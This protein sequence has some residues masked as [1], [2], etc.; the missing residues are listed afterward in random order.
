M[1]LL[2]NLSINRRLWLILLLAVGLSLA[3]Y[4]VMLQLIDSGLRAGKAEKIQHSLETSLGILQYFHG[5][6][7]AGSLTR[8]QAQTQA[9]TAVRGLRYAGDNYYWINDLGPVM[10]MHPT[11]TKLE[12]QDLSTIK[13]PDGKALFNEMVK[14]ANSRG[15]G[16]VDYRWPKPGS[17][18]P[19]PKISYVQLFQPWG[20]IIGTGVYID[21]IESE[22]RQLVIKTGSIALLICG[23][24]AVLVLLISRSVTQPMEQVV[25]ALDNIASG[26]GD[27]TQHLDAQGHD[28]LTQLAN[29]FNQFEDKLRQL[30]S[31]L[32]E[33]A[34]TL[35]QSSDELDQIS[36]RG[37]QQ[38]Q[39]QAQQMDL[40][41]TAINQVPTPYRMWPAM[42]NRL[43][44]RCATRSNRR[45][46]ATAAFSA[47]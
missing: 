22:F 40:V 18:D 14:V 10:V 33:A 32:S 7:Q 38:S 30:I 45:R 1:N 21:D 6:E 47:A 37:Q 8:E 35:D 5:L 17:T 31:R 28:E 34:S 2:R 23:L 20:W 9:K 43:Q 3:L 26:E 24:L 16:L 29:S 44:P 36:Q 4:L 46:Q 11:N 12:G 25:Q 15:A 41:A 19:V 13:D 42:P 27:L 39:S